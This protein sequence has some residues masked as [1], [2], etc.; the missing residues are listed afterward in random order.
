MPTQ[1]AGRACHGGHAALLTMLANIANLPSITLPAGVTADG[2]PIGLMV[3]AALNLLLTS[4]LLLVFLLRS[5][6]HGVE[7]VA[8]WVPLLAILFVVLPSLVTFIGAWRS[9]QASARFIS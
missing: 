8:A 5:F 4:L 1:I 3:T 9:N 6:N 2:L 7:L